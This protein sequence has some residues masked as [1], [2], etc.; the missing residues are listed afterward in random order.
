MASSVNRRMIA[1]AL[2]PLLLL[3]QPSSASAELDR[4]QAVDAVAAVHGEDDLLVKLA[5]A[6]G[7][8]PGEAPDTAGGAVIAVAAG[9][10]LAPADRAALLGEEAE[11]LD[12]AGIAASAEA[13]IAR[14]HETYLAGSG[15]R[16]E[17]WAQLVDHQRLSSA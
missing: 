11:R 1:L 13:L 12:A 10:V 5:R 15:V 16:D 6:I 2:G 14:R 9:A 3:G 4:S 7:S 8:Q 17:V